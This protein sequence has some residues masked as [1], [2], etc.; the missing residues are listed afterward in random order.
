MS[1]VVGRC[2]T[3]AGCGHDGYKSVGEG[4]V[5]SQFSLRGGLAVLAVGAGLREALKKADGHLLSDSVL[6]LLLDLSSSRTVL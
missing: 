2:P 6:F 4:T 1:V 3:R 5:A